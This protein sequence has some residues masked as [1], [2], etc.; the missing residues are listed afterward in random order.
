[1]PMAFKRF[2]VA[3]CIFIDYWAPQGNIFEHSNGLSADRV[4]E[5]IRSVLETSR[6]RSRRSNR[7]T[8]VD[9]IRFLDTH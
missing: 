8:Q 1:M 7:L 3:L 5:G 6:I 4:A 2:G 9:V